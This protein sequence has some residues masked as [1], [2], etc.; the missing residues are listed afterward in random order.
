MERYGFHFN[1]SDVHVTV[2]VGT[3]THGGREKG[4]QNL[5][6]S[7]DQA[8]YQAKTSGRNRVAAAGPE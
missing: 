3:A 4:Y 1:D 5:I 6:Q 7:A 2:S 8:L